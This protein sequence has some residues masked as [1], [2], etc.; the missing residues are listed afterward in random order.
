[1]CPTTFCEFTREETAQS[2]AS[3]FAQQVAKYGYRIAIR[4]RGEEITY[5]E[6]NATANA[7]AR[8]IV[9]Q[10]DPSNK[11]IVLLLEQD[12]NE[13]AAVLACFKA[14]KVCVPLQRDCDRKRAGQ[15]VADTQPQLLITDGKNLLRALAAADRA[16]AIINLDDIDLSDRADNLL[17]PI[18]PDAFAYILYT[19][20]S[21]GHPKGV[22]QSH[23]NLLHDLR[24]YTNCFQI[25]TADRLT[26]FA[27]CSGAQGMKTAL[28][29][30]VNGATVC[31]WDVKMQGLATLASWL[32]QESITIYIS[33]PT[34]FRNFTD[35]LSGV[36]DL[37]K[38]RL[39]KLGSE[40]LLLEDVERYKKYFSRHC[41][42]VNWY[43]ST[44]IGNVSY[45]FIDK[46][47]EISTEVVA[48]GYPHADKQILLRDELGRPVGFDK[49]GEIA[50]KSRYLPIGYWR[51]SG[52]T[53][54][55]YLA[56]PNGGI[57]RI[58][59]T[60]D[61]GLMRSDGSLEYYGRKD[62]RV[63]VR[64]FSI[65]VKDIEA[66]LR[67]HPGVK[68]AVVEA[69]GD[70]TE[71][72]LIAYIVSAGSTVPTITELRRFLRM[73]VFEHMVPSGFVFLDSLPLTA[74]GKVDR[75]ALPQPTDARPKL[76]S[77]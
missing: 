18:S 58:C 59:L 41:V 4:S 27:P 14:G 64:G 48:L 68:E 16:C 51:R 10:Q 6:L 39:I 19:S 2:V 42:L 45:K 61:L 29:A 60:G 7:I 3:R 30:L 50:V 63:K 66:V 23:R 21:T 40:P 49:I 72:R 20:G 5:S 32:V 22:V 26:L 62:S 11:P 67:N 8:S 13:I 75:R 37:S 36:E 25:S 56:D 76:E 69:I 47:S 73:S 44:E 24:G 70:S 46:G 53:A 15:I 43:S 31:L 17:L 28:S 65:D 57:E 9:A 55:K 38:I 54:A 71:K 35:M 12:A 33:A 77:T 34:I 52:L 74:N 1:M